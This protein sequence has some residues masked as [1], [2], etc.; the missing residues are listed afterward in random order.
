MTKAKKID[1]QR[2]LEIRRYLN[3]IATHL[4]ENRAV[5]MIGAGFSKNADGNMPSWNELAKEFRKAIKV[6]KKDQSDVLCLAEEVEC[7]KNRSYLDSI[8]ESKAETK[9]APSEMHRRLLSLPWA[10]VFTTNYDTLLERTLP[11]VFT[12]KYGVVINKDDL[13]NEVKPR[14]IKLHGS[15]CLGGVRKEHKP[16]IITK[17]DY[18][19]YPV[20]NAPLVN[21]FRQA[22]LEN[23]VCLLGFSGDDPNFLEWIGWVRDQLTRSGPKVYLVNPSHIRNSQ[24][25]LLGKRHIKILNLSGFEGVPD[26]D[27][28]KALKKFFEYLESNTVQIKAWSDVQ[29]FPWERHGTDRKSTYEG[30]RDAFVSLKKQYPNWLI[31]PFDYQERL[32]HHIMFGVR[33]MAQ[34]PESEWR[35]CN[36]HFWHALTS[37]MRQCWLPL[38]YVGSFLRRIENAMYSFLD[39]VAAADVGGV[40][41]RYTEHRTL[42]VDIAQDLLFSYRFCGQQDEWRKLMS[43]LEANRDKLYASTDLRIDIENVKFQISQGNL[44]DVGRKVSKLIWRAADYFAKCQVVALAAEFGGSHDVKDLARK[45]LDQIRR[46]MTSGRYRDYR[47]MSIESL[48]L[49]YIELIEKGD[50]IETSVS[51]DKTHYDASTRQFQLKVDNCDVVEPIVKLAQAMKPENVHHSN[52]PV[53]FSMRKKF[54]IPGFTWNAPSVPRAVSFLM[55]VDYIGIPLRIGRAPVARDELQKALSN[56]D[57]PNTY[58]IPFLLRNSDINVSLKT[59]TR[60][61]LAQMTAKDILSVYDEVLSLCKMQLGN[62]DGSV[63]AVESLLLI[64]GRMF[65][66]VPFNK[67]QDALDIIMLSYKSSFRWDVTK[68]LKELVRLLVDASLVDEIALMIKPLCETEIVYEGRDDWGDFERC[69]HPITIVWDN[70]DEL[71]RA[72]LQAE[73]KNM[74]LG[75]VVDDLLSRVKSSES[76]KR[77]RSWFLSPLVIL[78]LCDVCTD[79]QKAKIIPRLRY[80]LVDSS[81]YTYLPFDVENAVELLKEDSEFH[82]FQRQSLKDY[83]GSISQSRNIKHDIQEFRRIGSIGAFKWL[84]SKDYAVLSG[85]LNRYCEDIKDRLNNDAD[86][87]DQGVSEMTKAQTYYGVNSTLLSALFWFKDTSFESS[88]MDVTSRVAD[89]FEVYDLPNLVFR[90]NSIGEGGW[91]LDQMKSVQQTVRMAFASQKDWFVLD[92]LQTLCFCLGDNVIKKGVADWIGLIEGLV[93]WIPM[94]HFNHMVT[95]FVAMLKAYGIGEDCS[96]VVNATKRRLYAMLAE[97]DYAKETGIDFEI[98]V[99]GR[100]YAARLAGMIC[101]M[102]NGNVDSVV[103]SWRK[104][105]EN[106][107]EFLEVGKAWQSGNRFISVIK[108]NQKKFKKA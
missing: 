35:K 83:I 76:D 80:S 7:E 74:S 75:G 25:K 93:S 44:H 54:S 43:L 88:L 65:C 101:A 48:L 94:R 29:K 28:D 12:R 8:L 95:L 66:R 97:C 82:R 34:W 37:I 59:F 55:M 86:T 104:I 84:E 4:R 52:K 71:D 92:A 22:L 64:L 24:K 51:G 70:L 1:R 47:L 62:K 36:V 9:A 32:R 79:K 23:V 18:R 105:C 5:V 68:G 100:A 81:K 15:F 45:T 96:G 91:S 38:A 46:A 14:I 63:G 21:T 11:L 10:D 42:W 90:A 39:K 49:F 26:E 30:V 106:E 87:N 103:E 69:E 102:G 98:K 50:N 53:E 73:M 41:V 2:E 40:G 13:P 107:D 19:R 89:V 56:P 27:H 3:D 57:V 17:E 60:R 99:F 85:M 77:K 61:F 108:E 6:G 20:E 72:Y 33:E 16:Y 78:M 31:A 67:R 58:R